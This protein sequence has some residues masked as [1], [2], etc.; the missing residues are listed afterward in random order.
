MSEERSR[1]KPR[2]RIRRRI[3]IALILSLSLVGAAYGFVTFTQYFPSVP[4]GAP[5]P[6]LDA[7][8]GVTPP[9]ALTASPATV[10]AGLDFAIVYSCP[11]G[12]AAITVTNGPMNS[13]P[14]E[15]PAI[16]AGGMPTTLSLIPAGAACTASA[17]MALA[18]STSV[19]IPTGDYNYC[20]T[21]TTAPTTGVVSFTV[22]WS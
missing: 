7:N 20:A 17:G 8:C 10:V 6:D 2:F 11:S 16:G 19:S 21:G 5:P 14:T 9:T 18:Q 3:V 1:S 4:V 15:A 12:T 22:T 13:I